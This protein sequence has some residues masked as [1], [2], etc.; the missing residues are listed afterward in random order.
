MVVHQAVLLHV[1]S[2]Q[3]WRS[4]GVQLVHLHPQGG[5]KNFRLNLQGKCVSA[6][7]WD[8]KCTPRQKQESIFRTVFAGRVRFGGVFRRSL[9][10][11]IVNFFGK[12]KCT[13]R[14]NPGY[15]YV[16]RPKPVPTVSP[17]LFVCLHQSVDTSTMVPVC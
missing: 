11:T 16:P 5:E 7:P 1:A 6:P 8:T 14:Q 2:T 10:A 12:K 15:A 13:P 4:Q 9:R 3:T 17:W